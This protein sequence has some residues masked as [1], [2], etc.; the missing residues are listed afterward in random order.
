MPPI[1][2]PTIAPA[3]S[4]TTLAAASLATDSPTGSPCLTSCLAPRTV[5]ADPGDHVHHWNSLPGIDHLGQHA[6]VFPGRLRQGLGGTASHMLP[7]ACLS[8]EVIPH[9]A[10]PAVEQPA[11]SVFDSAGVGQI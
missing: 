3:V 9:V 8:G 10:D 2:P 11:E 7:W 1:A 5:P 6:W 4:P